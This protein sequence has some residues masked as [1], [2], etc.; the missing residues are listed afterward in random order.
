MR[1]MVLV[2][3]YLIFLGSERTNDSETE[4]SIKETLTLNKFGVP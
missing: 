2:A 4:V 1:E 3:D